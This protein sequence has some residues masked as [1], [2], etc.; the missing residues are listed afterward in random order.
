VQT[1]LSKRHS[2]DIMHRQ[3]AHALLGGRTCQELLLPFDNKLD[4]IEPCACTGLPARIVI[5]WAYNTYT[6]LLR[7]QL[8]DD[9]RY[10]SRCTAIITRIISMSGALWS[11]T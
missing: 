9:R 5:K 11:A 10:C 2:L 4:V 7:A 3:A 6:I 8:D 1:V